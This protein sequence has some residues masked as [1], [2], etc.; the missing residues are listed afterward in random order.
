[1]KHKAP[2]KSHC[3]GITLLQLTRMFPDEAAARHWFEGRRLR[4]EGLKRPTS[5]DLAAQA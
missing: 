1:M 4:H 5:T 2:G 3:H